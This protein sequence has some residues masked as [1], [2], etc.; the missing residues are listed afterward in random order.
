MFS[1]KATVLLHF[2]S[3]RIVFL[4]FHGVVISL[5]TFT[6]SQ[7][8]FC[9]HCTH[10]L[11][12]SVQKLYKSLFLCDVKNLHTKKRLYVSIKNCIISHT[13][14]QEE[15]I[16]FCKGMIILM[17]NPCLMTHYRIK[18]THNNKKAAARKTACIVGVSAIA[19][20]TI[21]SIIIMCKKGM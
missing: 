3:I 20:S 6:T 16:F 18:S 15:F 4:V 19:V 13:K 7:C 5:F 2:D 9:S 10:L 12:L 8:D 1:A 11:S 17:N 21:A 14:C